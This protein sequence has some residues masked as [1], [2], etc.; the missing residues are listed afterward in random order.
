M[1]VSSTARVSRDRVGLHIAP[2]AVDGVQRPRNLELVDV[3][4]E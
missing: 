1:T 3:L 2:E 4:G